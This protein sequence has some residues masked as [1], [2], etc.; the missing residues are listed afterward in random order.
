M[1][2]GEKL[3]QLRGEQH[4]TQE[5]LAAYLNVAPQT[6][7]K[8]ENGSTAP[9][10]G[11]LVPL[12]NFFGVTID[13]L[14]DRTAAAEQADIDR[15]FEENRKLSSGGFVKEELA[16]W[17]E[18]AAKYPKNYDCL[19]MLCYALLSTLY[20]DT[21]LEEKN[22]NAEEI[23][24]IGKQILEDCKNT[25]IRQNILQALVFVYSNENLSLADEKEAEKYAYMASSFPCCQEVLLEKI[26]I[27]EEGKKKALRQAHQNNLHFMDSITLH[28]YRW[29]YDSTEEKIFAEESALKLWEILIYD[30]NYLF[31]H[32]RISEIHLSLAVAYASL[33]NREKV[34]FHLQKALYHGKRCSELPSEETNY[35]SLFVKEAVSST[36]GVGKN[37]TETEEELMRQGMQKWSCFD[38]L[39]ED[40]EF[41]AL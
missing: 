8:W 40:E 5:K 34:L 36:A 12:A 10:I 3:K 1:T 4:I 30:G 38:F 31:Y 26:G 17:R 6:V 7:S 23:A 14:F 27:T 28:F 25:G 35:T 39:R 11:L 19:E 29:N 9:D 21:P 33:K 32:C 37:Y 24:R 2:I 15:Y 13:E 18:A 20:V 22:K 16:L 41:Q